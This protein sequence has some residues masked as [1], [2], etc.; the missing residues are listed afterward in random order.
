MSSL[1]IILAIVLGEGDD[2]LENKLLLCVCN[3]LCC[4]CC[5]GSIL[6]GDEM[7]SE[8]EGDEEDAADVYTQA[9]GDGR[10]M[11]LKLIIFIV[12]EPDDEAVDEVDV[13]EVVKF[14]EEEGDDD[15]LGCC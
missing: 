13:D 11:G 15:V 3:W 6:T 14:E 1:F 8:G 9:A 10:F 7:L 5:C 4:C 2:A 12:V